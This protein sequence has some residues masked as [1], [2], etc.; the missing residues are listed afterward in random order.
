M[1]D[2][3]ISI[4]AYDLDDTSI[5]EELQAA[6]ENAE[7]YIKLSTTGD[8]DGDWQDTVN[9][10]LPSNGSVTFY[11]QANPPVNAVTGG[12][13]CGLNTQTDVLNIPRSKNIILNGTVLTGNPV[14]QSGGVSNPAIILEFGNMQFDNLTK[15]KVEDRIN[16]PSKTFE[17]DYSTADYPEEFIS[18]QQIIISQETETFLNGNV[19]DVSEKGLPGNHTYTLTGRDQALA[20]VE[21]KFSAAINCPIVQQAVRF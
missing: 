17:V 2:L 18:G 19:Q 8:L 21:Q 12:W 9:V 16:D 20:L 11:V 15:F 4:S 13:M 3:N 14:I 10:D 6:S 1:A 5:P 7:E